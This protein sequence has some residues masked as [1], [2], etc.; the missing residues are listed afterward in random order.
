MAGGLARIR[1]S[2]AHPGV[3]WTVQRLL[4]ATRVHRHLVTQ[5][6][7][8]E[9]GQRVLDIGC[10]PGRLLDVLPRVEYL[11]LDPS[12]EYIAAARSRYGDEAAFVV[13]DASG[14]DLDREAPFD[15]ALAI[16]VLHHLDD[17][18]ATELL[19]LAS[20]S[21]KPGGRLVTLDPART[22]E[23]SALARWLAT[24]DRG[25]HVRSPTDYRALAESSF[26]EVGTTVEEGLARIPYTHVVMECEA[27]K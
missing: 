14:A 11:G 18:E 20:R 19:A 24:R 17:S 4:G 16:G 21:L 23:Q 15:V 3:Y 9:P 12:Q 6:A 2:L 25:E 22:P 26:P 1:S 5:H 8:V 13:A 7:R 10:G 27:S